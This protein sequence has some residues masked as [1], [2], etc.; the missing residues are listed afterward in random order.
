VD[1][2]GRPHE[3]GEVAEPEAGMAERKRRAAIGFTVHTG[4]A[5]AVAVSGPPAELLDRRKVTLATDPHQRF[6][7]HV[8]AEEPAAAK[9]L[10]EEA[11][12]VA[13]AGAKAAL[14]RLAADLPAFALVVALRPEKSLPPLEAILSSHPLRHTAEGQL[15][16]RAI[17]EAARELGLPVVVPAALKVPAVGK[18]GPPWGKDQKEGAALAWAALGER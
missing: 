14:E 11:F 15:Y 4:W 1:G 18:P 8:A 6:V 12:A 17:T 2:G 9:R 10:V 7:Y 5:A 3:E 16:R 13:R